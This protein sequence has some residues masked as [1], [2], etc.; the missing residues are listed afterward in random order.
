MPTPIRLTIVLAPLLIALAACSTTH[1]PAVDVVT[2]EGVV[3]ARGNEPF[4]R[5]ILETDEG[6]VYALR[7]SEEDR[8]RF[9]TPARLRATGRLYVDDWQGYS[10]AHIDVS[11]FSPIE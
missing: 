6:L 11:E 2:V 1:G 5:Y 4:V 7:I 8:S 9:Q 3:T 10:F